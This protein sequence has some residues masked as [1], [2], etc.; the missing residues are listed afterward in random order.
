MVFFAFLLHLAWEFA[1][2]PLFA[3]MPSAS[4]WAAVQV[5]GRAAV[6][7]ALIALVAFWGVAATARSRAWVLAPTRGQLLVFLG[8]GI[9]IT[10]VMEWLATQVLGRW[11]YGPEM[12][13][14]P[15]LGVGVSPLLQWVVV[16]P[17]VL[18]IVRRQLLGMEALRR[19]REG[20]GL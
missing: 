4:H 18:W 14:V 6:G 3:R 16:P 12:P 9:L 7:D 5:C 17:L 10:I 20:G 2:V 8:I 19:Q 13:I 15:V 1:Q 11:A